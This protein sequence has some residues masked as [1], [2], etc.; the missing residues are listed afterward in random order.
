MPAQRPGAVPFGLF[1]GN[2]MLRQPIGNAPLHAPQRSPGILVPFEQ[3]NIPRHRGPALQADG[4]FEAPAMLAH[5]A[6]QLID[7]NI[8]E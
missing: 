2:V 3:V 4:G 6:P 1:R 8:V 5:V 7:I